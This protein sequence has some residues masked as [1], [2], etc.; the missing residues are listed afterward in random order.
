M[1]ER[2]RWN[3]R[4]FLKVT[5]RTVASML[6][7]SVLHARVVR[8]RSEGEQRFAYVGFGANDRESGGIAVF[9][10]RNN[11]WR[12]T[13]TVPSNSPSSLV[14]DASERVLYAVNAVDEYEGL[15][16]GTV[17]SFAI[18]AGDGTLRLLNRQP[19][20]LS[21]I[22]PGDAAVTPDGRMLVVSVAGGGAYNVL[23]I[24]ADGSLGGVT[25]IWKER[26]SGPRV[27]QGSSHSQM[28][29]FDRMG[30]AL[31]ADLGSDR[32]SVLE[33][34]GGKLNVVRSHTVAPGKGPHQIAFHPNGRILFVANG[35]EASV[36]CYQ[37]NVDRGQIIR[38][39]GEFATRCSENAV[40]LAMAMDPTGD[41][42]YTTHQQSRDGIS[43]WRIDQSTGRLQHLQIAGEH[44]PP[45]HKLLVTSDGKTLVGWSRE[46]G[47]IFAW[48][49]ATGRIGRGVQLANVTA[50][51]SMVVKSL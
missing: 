41:V 15:P 39:L 3:R 50:P 40:G 14:L 30:R 6:V 20:S 48:P 19:L 1:K 23:P 16:S 35:L 11:A 9:D 21:A 28:V 49:I 2:S 31:S 38:S 42:L 10:C 36:I 47:G 43:A 24:R 37:Y 17:E 32:L 12:R 26:G 29:A 45:Q 27:Q 5:G 22:R 25:G 51:L 44:E 8:R 46:A 7:T 18:D 13:S 34:D 33:T 4:E